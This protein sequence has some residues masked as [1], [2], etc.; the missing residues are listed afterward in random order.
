MFFIYILFPPLLSFHLTSDAC[1]VVAIMDL[2]NFSL[3]KLSHHWSK[4]V[5][6]HACKRLKFTN[7]YTGAAKFRKLGASLQET[8]TPIKFKVPDYTFLL[9]VNNNYQSF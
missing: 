1:A 9:G 4:T 2:P 6:I 3:I 5:S 8:S 7:V